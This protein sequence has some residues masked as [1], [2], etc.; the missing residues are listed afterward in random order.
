MPHL[1][2]TAHV[3]LSPAEAFALAH[4]VGEAR[5]AWDPAVT[6]S[7]W[8]RRAT[9]PAAG[10]S[11]FTRSPSGR[12]RILTFELVDEGRLSSARLVKGQPLLRDYGEGMRFEPGDGDGT[13]FTWKVTYKLAAPFAA[14]VIGRAIAP[15]FERELRARLDGFVRAAS[16]LA[17]HR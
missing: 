11:M 8:L 9:G 13:T 14:P 2:A 3:P 6:S 16:L 12:R 7:R 10:A 5:A 17:S 4:E 1:E 15:V